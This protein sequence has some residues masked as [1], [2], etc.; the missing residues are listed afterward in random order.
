MKILKT[1]LVGAVAILPMGYAF[2]QGTGGPTQA[3]GALEG[4]DTTSTGTIPT[5]PSMDRDSNASSPSMNSPGR[6]LDS[7]TKGAEG[8]DDNPK[9][10]DGSGR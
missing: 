8:R 4:R 5:R 7:M 2:A 6:G 3:E 9:S 10:R 1:L